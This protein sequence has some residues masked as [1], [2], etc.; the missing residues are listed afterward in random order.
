MVLKK[1]VHTY[2][3]SELPKLHCLVP[4]KIICVAKTESVVTLKTI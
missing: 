3:D 2:L 1:S 4:E